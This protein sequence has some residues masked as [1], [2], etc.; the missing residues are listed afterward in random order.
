MSLACAVITLITKT[1][2]V[3]YLK[4]PK[5]VE[6]LTPPRNVPYRK[7]YFTF[8]T[9]YKKKHT[10]IQLTTEGKMCHRPSTRMQHKSNVHQQIATAK[11]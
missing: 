4:L 1:L 7:L 5:H 9:V 10:K 11:R 8:D 2:S 3:K 6:S